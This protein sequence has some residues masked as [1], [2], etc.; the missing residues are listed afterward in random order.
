MRVFL[1][2]RFRILLDRYNEDLLKYMDRLG[3]EEARRQTEGQ[4][5]ECVD[6]RNALQAHVEQHE[7][8]HFRDSPSENSLPSP[9]RSMRK[10]A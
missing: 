6:A 10:Q 2:Q 7:C 8:L 9:K 1:T 3:L 5:L 4:F